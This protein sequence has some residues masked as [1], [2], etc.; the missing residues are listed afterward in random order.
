MP[1]NEG[2]CRVRDDYFRYCNLDQQGSLWKQ[3]TINNLRDVGCNYAITDLKSLI[4]L[5]THPHSTSVPDIENNR[6]IPMEKLCI[7]ENRQI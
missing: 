4:A 1:E 5:I 7:K 3:G 2:P 6:K